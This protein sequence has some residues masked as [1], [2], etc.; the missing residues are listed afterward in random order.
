MEANQ[1]Q[2][3]GSIV[4]TESV[5]TAKGQNFVLCNMNTP[6]PSGQTDVI[7]VCISSHLFNSWGLVPGDNVMLCGEVRSRNYY[8]KQEEKDRVAVYASAHAMVRSVDPLPLQNEAGLAGNICSDPVLRKTPKSKDVCTFTLAVDKNGA[9]KVYTEYIPCVVFAP[10]A[11]FAAGLKK[12]ESV[13]IT[14][15]MQSRLY[16]KK[17]KTQKVHEVVVNSLELLSNKEKEATRGWNY[18]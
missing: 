15:R 11:K 6:R 16:V 12:G 18:H 5:Q 13:G 4:S 10:L 3:S 14:G 7:P 8:D 17:G 1:L 2:I 9:E